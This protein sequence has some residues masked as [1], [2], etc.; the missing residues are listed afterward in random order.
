MHEILSQEKI[1]GRFLNFILIYF[2]GFLGVHKFVKGKRKMGFLY[3]FTVGLFCFGYIVDIL[4]S[5]VNIFFPLDYFDFDDEYEAKLILDQQEKERQRLRNIEMM[6]TEKKLAEKR[7]AEAKEKGL[8]HCPKCGSTQIQYYNDTTVIQGKNRTGAGVVTG[9]AINPV[10]GAVV[11]TSRKD[12][13]VK[14]DEGCVCL[15]CGTKWKP[16]SKF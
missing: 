14:K 10:V 12:N 1:S 4:L 7:I 8:A 9:L 11:G 3:L 15:N 16:T 13:K 6:E 2:T 5:I